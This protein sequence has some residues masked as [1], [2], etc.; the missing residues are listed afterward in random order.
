MTLI[1]IKR[2]DTINKF[3][4]GESKVPQNVKQNYHMSQQFY[5]K[6]T[7]NSDSDR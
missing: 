2:N 1:F 5:S 7:E 4:K 6:K 3:F